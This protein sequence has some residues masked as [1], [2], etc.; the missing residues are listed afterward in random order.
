MQQFT[1]P[2]FIDVE[3]KIIGPITTRQFI[4]LLVGFLLMGISYK[5]FDFSLFLTVSIL[6]LVITGTFAFV[7]INGRPFHFFILNITQTLKRPG[8][9]IWRNEFSPP[10][11]EGYAM[12]EKEIIKQTP[13]P[14]P[15]VEPSLSRLAELSLMVDTRGEYGGEED[16]ETKITAVK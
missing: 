6:T 4:I 14:A 11:M 1:I 12:N 7:R 3:D 2:Q 13:L 9:R 8:L 5:I 16:R 10:E 15:K